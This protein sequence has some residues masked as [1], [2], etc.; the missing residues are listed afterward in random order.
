MTMAD[1]A[2]GKLGVVLVGLPAD[3][4]EARAIAGRYAAHGYGIAIVELA[5]EDDVE[6]GLTLVSAAFQELRAAEHALVAV[7]GYDDGGRF[8]FLAV[9]RLG[10]SGAVAFRGLGIADHLA[11]ARSVKAPLS[12]HFADDD[13]RIPFTAVRAIKGAL[14][15]FGTVEIYRYPVFDADALKAAEGRAFAVLDG[16][17]AA[18]G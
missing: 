5:P 15:G 12:L 18:Q 9:T 11:E 7:A 16:L 4:L 6:A 2:R 3:P 10:A 1:G 17:G 13:A 14:E 8:A